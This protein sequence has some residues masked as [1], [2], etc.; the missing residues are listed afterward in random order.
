MSLEG[1]QASQQA[2]ARTQETRS[3]VRR[4]RAAAP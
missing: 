3:F 2:E 1:Y 4:V